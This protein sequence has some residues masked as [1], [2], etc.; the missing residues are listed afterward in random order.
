MGHVVKI[1]AA[2]LAGDEDEDGDVEQLV[3]ETTKVRIVHLVRQMSTALPAAVMQQA[4]AEM[5]P[6]E[7]A[8]ISAAIAAR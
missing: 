6:R 7:R 2:C 8:A 5:A 4:T 1:F 3:H